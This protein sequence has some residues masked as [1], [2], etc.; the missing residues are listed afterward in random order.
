MS[1]VLIQT[2]IRNAR[3]VLWVVINASLTYVAY[4]GGFS[5]PLLSADQRLRFIKKYILAHKSVN[6]VSP[7]TYPDYSDCGEVVALVKSLLDPTFVLSHSHQWVP[8]TATPASRLYVHTQCLIYPPCL[9]PPFNPALRAHHF[10]THDLP[11]FLDH[12]QA[13]L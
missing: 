11:T 7:K 12:S 10:N 5:A 13:F 8:F 1:H 4:G 6:I 3:K 9:P 2:I